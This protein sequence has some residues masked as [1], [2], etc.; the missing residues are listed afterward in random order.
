VKGG[1]LF[2]RLAS[3]DL[4]HLAV[5]GLTNGKLRK[6]LYQAGTAN[7]DDEKARTVRGLCMIEAARRFCGRRGM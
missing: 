1:K 7:S 5:R 6:A 2:N 4:P 3:T